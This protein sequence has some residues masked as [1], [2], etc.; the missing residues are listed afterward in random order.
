MSQPLE[1]AVRAALTIISE[2][3]PYLRVRVGISSGP[4]IGM[5]KDEEMQR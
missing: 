2:V 3:N 5:R 4:L 1:D